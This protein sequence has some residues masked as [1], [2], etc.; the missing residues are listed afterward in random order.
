MFPTAIKRKNL[1][2]QV[3]QMTQGL[4]RLAK[5]ILHATGFLFFR[6][7]ATATMNKPASTTKT[8]KTNQNQVSNVTRPRVSS[9]FVRPKTRLVQKNT[10]MPGSNH[11]HLRVVHDLVQAQDVGMMHLLH[12]GDLPL[13]AVHE[14]LFLAHLPADSGRQAAS[15]AVMG[16]IVVFMLW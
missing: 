5:L 6:A 7:E 11:V 15:R 4:S 1:F 14:R 9:W 13:D 12:D 8:G 16:V 2:G 3:R 10:F